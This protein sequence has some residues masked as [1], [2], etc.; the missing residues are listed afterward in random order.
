V[1]AHADQRVPRQD[2]QEGKIRSRVG[3]LQHVVK[4]AD[5]LV[6]V[7][8]EDKLEL[9]H[10][11]LTEDLQDNLIR[12]KLTGSAARFVSVRARGASPANG[13]ARGAGSAELMEALADAR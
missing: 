8:Q 2:F 10:R 5:G 12:T 11:H 4:I 1:K 7:N 3:A 9:S 6:R 13:A